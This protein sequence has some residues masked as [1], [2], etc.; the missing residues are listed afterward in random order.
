MRRRAGS[1]RRRRPR[2]QTL[3]GSRNWDY[4]YGW[5]RDSAMTLY[6]LL[7]AGYREEAESWRRWPPRAAAGAP[8]SCA[9]WYGISGERWPPELESLRGWQGSENSSP[10][11]IGNLAGLPAQP[12]VYGELSTCRT[13]RAKPSSR[14]STK[15]GR[16]RRRCCAA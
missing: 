4:R 5:I 2:C 13:P 10:V 7:N 16:C 11:R 3:G 14:R 1:S 6:A 15:P 8:S 12:D 9:S